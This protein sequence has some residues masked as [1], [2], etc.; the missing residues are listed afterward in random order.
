MKLFIFTTYLMYDGTLNVR[1][2]DLIP[3]KQ[4]NKSARS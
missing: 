2:V 3:K 4:K 1:I